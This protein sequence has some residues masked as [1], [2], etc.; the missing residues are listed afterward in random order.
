MTI[1]DDQLSFDRS[2]S[3]GSSAERSGVLDGTVDE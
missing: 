3:W 2:L 1:V